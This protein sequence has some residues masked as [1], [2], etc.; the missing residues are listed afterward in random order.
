MALY[1]KEN[2]IP[3]FAFY[4]FVLDSIHREALHFSEELDV[5]L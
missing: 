1:T 5:G 3:I 2:P 4:Y